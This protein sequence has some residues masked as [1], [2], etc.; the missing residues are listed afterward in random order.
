MPAFGK[1]S[2]ERLATCDPALIE[3]MEEAIKHHDFTIVCGHRGKED[4]DKAVAEGKS[5]RP[6]PTSAHNSLPSKAVDIAPF[7][8]GTNALLWGRSPAERERFSRLAGLIE[9]IAVAKGYRI[10][11]GGDFD[12][13]ENTAEGD[14]WDMPHIE[15]VG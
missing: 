11:W 13:D 10:I 4:Q 14:S 1:A 2:R 3:I 8:A 5:K 9:G 6:W 15:L 7:D 12:M